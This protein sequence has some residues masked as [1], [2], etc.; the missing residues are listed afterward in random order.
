VALEG[1][2]DEDLTPVSDESM[3]TSLSP[4]M[5]A[6]E[7]DDEEDDVTSRVKRGCARDVKTSLWWTL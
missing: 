7:G 1:V 4:Q 3:M 2:D 6:D 5:M